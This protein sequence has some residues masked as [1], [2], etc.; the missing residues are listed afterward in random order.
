[1]SVVVERGLA[2]CPRCVAVADYTFVESGPNSVR[3]EVHCGK[4]GEAYCEV[5][6]PVTPDFAAAVEALVVS[7]PP[8]RRRPSRCAAG[9]RWPGWPACGR[10][11]RHASAP[12]AGR[13]ASKRS[14]IQALGHVAMATS[15]APPRIPGRGPSWR[16][17]E[18]VAQLPQGLLQDPGDVHLRNPDAFGDLTLG[19]GLEEA[20]VEHGALALRQSG[21]QGSDRL[22]VGDAVELEVDLADGVGDHPRCRV[23]AGYGRVDGVDAVR[24]GGQHAVDDVLAAHVEQFGQLPGGGRPAERLRQFHCGPGD[25]AVPVFEAARNV[26]RP[27]VI[28]EVPAHLAHHGGHCE[29]HEVRALGR[30]RTG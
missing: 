10:R 7:P 28:A 30:G 22:L 25:V 18:L 1:M 27:T 29:G 19:H 9:G 13:I 12:A 24:L 4:C 21:E 20:E 2:R 14:T 5:H 8:F 6:T 26:H 17:D 16:V 3:Y 11:G 23:A 15:E